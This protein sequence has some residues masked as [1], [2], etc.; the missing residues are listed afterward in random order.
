MDLQI[1]SIALAR[2]NLLLTAH[3]RDFAQVPGEAAAPGTSGGRSLGESCA[4]KTGWIDARR[5]T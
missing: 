3:L 5:R 1:A 4:A 2:G